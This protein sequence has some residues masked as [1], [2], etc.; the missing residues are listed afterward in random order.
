M[1]MHTID[2]QKHDDTRSPRARACIAHVLRMYCA[3]IA[4]AVMTTRRRISARIAH[5][6]WRM[7][8]AARARTIGTIVI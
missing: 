4:R 7:V 3:C 6:A 8:H 1:R 2:V 5:G